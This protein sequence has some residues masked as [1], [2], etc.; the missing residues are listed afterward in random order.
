MPTA[1]LKASTIHYAQR[2]AGAPAIVM[3]H[4][5]LCTHDD[6]RFQIA[7]FARRH[8]VVAPDLHGHGG[9]CS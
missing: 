7:H 6:W 2:G 3:V 1:T 5:A 9:C 4:G 8:R